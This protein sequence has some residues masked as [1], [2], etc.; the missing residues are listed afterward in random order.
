MVIFPVLAGRYARRSRYPDRRLSSRRFQAQLF[1]WR[2]AIRRL[3][4]HLDDI[5][6]GVFQDSMR[7]VLRCM[8]FSAAEIRACNSLAFSSPATSSSVCQRPIFSAA[9]RFAAQPEKLII[10]REHL[11]VFGDCVREQHPATVAAVFERVLIARLKGLL[12]ARARSANRFRL[13]RNFSAAC[14]TG[15][16]FTLPGFTGLVF[17]LLRIRTFFALLFCEFA[18]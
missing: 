8:A 11:G 15:I 12:A 14:V 1:Q 13:W 9:V 6:L 18:P 4:L 7:A 17:P 2:F 16:L 10:E 3:N 5:A